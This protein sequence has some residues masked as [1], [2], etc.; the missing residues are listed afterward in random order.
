LVERY[1]DAIEWDLHHY[2]Q[3]DITDFYNGRYTP[4]KL[5]VFIESLPRNS[6]YW[7]ARSQ[8]VEL[9]RESVRR[10]MKSRK[11]PPPEAYEFSPELEYLGVV[12][13][14]LNVI[15]TQIYNRGAKKG[16]QKRPKPLRLPTPR[17]AAAMVHQQDRRDAFAH[18][19]AV[20]RFVPEEEYREIARSSQIEGWTTTQ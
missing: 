3:L 4:R 7:A 16:R 13:E 9:Y 14:Q 6:R 20:V 15:S 19:E 18:I 2:W 8:D 1:G 5:W 12:A 10:G 11:S 17:T